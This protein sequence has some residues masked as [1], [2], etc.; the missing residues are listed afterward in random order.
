M[1]KVDREHPGTNASFSVNVDLKRLCQQFCHSIASQEIKVD[2]F[3][4]NEVLQR[5][6]PKVECDKQDVGPIKPS[7]LAVPFSNCLTSHRL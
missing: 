4:E 7:C 5:E 6:L 1:H 2:A 3:D